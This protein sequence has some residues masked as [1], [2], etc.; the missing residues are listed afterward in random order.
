MLVRMRMHGRVGEVMRPHLD[1]KVTVMKIVRSYLCAGRVTKAYCI[2]IV[3]VSK[4]EMR[5][6]DVVIAK[7]R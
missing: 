1:H 3:R 2:S 7:F 4:V 5:L 6:Y